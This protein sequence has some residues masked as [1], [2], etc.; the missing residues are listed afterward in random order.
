MEIGICHFSPKGERLEENL[1][2]HTDFREEPG[3]KKLRWMRRRKESLSDWTAY[4]FSHFDALVFIGAA[5][6]A[7]RAIAPFVRDKLLDP[8]V[9]CMD[10]GGRFVIPLLSGHVGGANALAKSLAGWIHATPVLTTSTDGA[11]AFACDLWAKKNGL[12]ILNR[13]GIQAVSSSILRG[14]KVGVWSE[15]GWEEG[16]ALP[17]ELVRIDHIQSLLQAAGHGEEKAFLLVFDSYARARGFADHL[18]MAGLEGE[19]KKPGCLILYARPYIVGI[20]CRAGVDTDR[21]SL[22]Y[23]AF[24]QKHE[25]DP[26][27]VYALATVD[28]KAK[29]KALLALHRRE[30]IELF[31]RSPEELMA[32]QGDFHHSDFVMQTLGCDNVCERAAFLLAKELSSEEES[33]QLLVQR[34]AKEKVTFAVARCKKLLQI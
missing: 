14:E 11:R 21:V 17:G 8:A 18:T 16:S 9:I 29:E 2:C 6:I 28:R 34:E 3:E 7:I 32:V 4:A 5:G 26:R 30:G 23:H 10:D 13:E 31:T 27:E 19:R 22:Q 20:G 12:G 25:I 33:A 24:L 1:I 15:I